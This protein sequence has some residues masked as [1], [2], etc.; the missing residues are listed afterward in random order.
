MNPVWPGSGARL[1]MNPVTEVIA[2][3]CVTLVEHVLDPVPTP[4]Q[5]VVVSVVTPPAVEQTTVVVVP[6]LVVVVLELPGQFPSPSVT[7]PSS[8]ASTIG[9]GWISEPVFISTWAIVPGLF[10]PEPAVVGAAEVKYPT[11]FTKANPDDAPI[12]EKSC[13]GAPEESSM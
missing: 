2:G 11:W 7:S 1:R 13:K 8:G 4:V 12:D 6:P 9:V 3:P 5:T 10:W